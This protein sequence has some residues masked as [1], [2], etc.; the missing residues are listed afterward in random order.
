MGFPRVLAVL[1][2]VTT[3][4]AGCGHTPKRPQSAPTTSAAAKPIPPARPACGEPAAVL[5]AMSTRAKLAQLRHEHLGF[6]SCV[7]VQKAPGDAQRRSRKAR[8]IVLGWD[9]SRY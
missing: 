4:M 9:G 2:A 1:A 3:L 7:P 6:G 5:A 8:G